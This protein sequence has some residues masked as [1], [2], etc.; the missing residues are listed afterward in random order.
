VSGADRYEF[1]ENYVQMTTSY[2]MS[3][4]NAKNFL[5]KKNNFGFAFS[6]PM[7]DLRYVERTNDNNCG[8]DNQLDMPQDRVKTIAFTGNE[9]SD[10]KNGNPLRLTLTGNSYTSNFVSKFDL[11]NNTVEMPCDCKTTTVDSN[12]TNEEVIMDK[13]LKNSKCGAMNQGEFVIGTRTNICK[14]ILPP[15]EAEREKEVRKD[16]KKKWTIYLII[17]VLVTLFLTA[18]IVGLAMKMCCV[19]TEV[20]PR[21]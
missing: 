15:T 20:T 18:L 6:Q 13:L 19:N 9:I 10:P 21:A 4:Q 1:E 16:V 7:V 8:S 11:V 14:G 2:A 12:P 17:A 3:I 5:T